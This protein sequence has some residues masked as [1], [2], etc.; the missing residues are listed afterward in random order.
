MRATSYT[1]STRW[2]YPV[3]ASD[4]GQLH[5]TPRSALTV[6][7]D[8]GVWVVPP[9]Q[10]VWVPAG[11]AHV[12]ETGPGAARRTLYVRASLARRLP[13]T[14]R[15]VHVSP[16]LRELLLRAIRWQTLD[17]A[18]PEQRNLMAILLDELAV[19]PVAPV[20]LPMPRDARAV[21]AARA[22]RDAPGGRHTLATAA[23]ESGASE[24][25]LERLFRGETGL[26]FG[27][28][29]QR[30][31]MLHALRLLADRTN[32][33]QTAIA[34]GYESTSAFVAAFRRATGTT[35][36]QYFKVV[37]TR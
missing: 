34:V 8:S 27:T 15:A 18:K 17:R 35:P 6:S 9:H 29:R 14:C 5:F 32:V 23:R 28:W 16:L 4:W 2:T 24:R 11:I 26:G 7:T 3:Q 19:L 21:R 25:T 33:T 12:L 20:D 36:G 1:V 13:S 30:A 37:E 31:R 22:V 10:A